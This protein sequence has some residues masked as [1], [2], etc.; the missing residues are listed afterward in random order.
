M[1]PRYICIHVWYMFI[2]ISV[3]FDTLNLHMWAYESLCICMYMNDGPGEVHL[4]VQRSV[5]H[6]GNRL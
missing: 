3:Q 2:H 1:L 4:A 5:C 6:L